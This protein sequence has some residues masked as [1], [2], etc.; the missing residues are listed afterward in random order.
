M[1]VWSRPKE[2][3][4][5]DFQPPPYS[6]HWQYSDDVTILDPE[7]EKREVA[8]LGY[9]SGSTD[10]GSRFLADQKVSPY[11]DSE[12]RQRRSRAKAEQ[13]AINFTNKSKHTIS[14][15]RIR[16]KDSN[17]SSHASKNSWLR[18]LRKKH[19]RKR[20]KD[21][22]SIAQVPGPPK[23]K[24]TLIPIHPPKIRNKIILGQDTISLFDPTGHS[25]F[26]AS[27]FTISLE[28]TLLE[29]RPYTIC[30]PVLQR[31]ENR[32]FESAL[33]HFEILDM[34]T[35]YVL[36]E[37]SRFPSPPTKIEQVSKRG[38]RK[39]SASPNPAI[40][41]N[42]CTE[43]S[44][45]RP[46]QQTIT[47]R[48]SP[49]KSSTERLFDGLRI[50]DPTLL[51]GRR[52]KLRL[53]PSVVLWSAKTMQEVFGFEDVVGSW[54]DL[55]GLPLVLKCSEDGDDEGGAEFKIVESTKE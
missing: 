46:S 33:D 28:S 3:H 14:H 12:L 24:A 6:E 18:S 34:E 11:Y 50:T 5:I 38:S 32:N 1:G 20:S 48:P 35:G 31:A 19:A 2:E 23:F 8:L 22:P 9:E 53:K 45:H 41:R 21:S 4:V 25:Y 39:A 30:S 43:L 36:S 29:N 26:E 27:P 54:P 17:N 51:V 37:K 15:R 40:H 7:D 44:P 49:S 55:Y 13:E 10:H 42:T 52:L 47:C 16:S